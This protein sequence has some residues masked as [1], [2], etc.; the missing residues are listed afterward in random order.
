MTRRVDPLIQD[1]INGYHLD[2]E[3]MRDARLR[4]HPEATRLSLSPPRPEVPHTGLSSRA[5]STGERTALRSAAPTVA[6]DLDHA[7]RLHSSPMRQTSQ[8]IPAARAADD[9]DRLRRQ[10]REVICEHRAVS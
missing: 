2:T 4:E 5:L 3:R 9:V 7:E 10:A 8:G 1:I 6:V